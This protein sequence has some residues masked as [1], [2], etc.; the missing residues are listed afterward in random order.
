MALVVGGGDSAMEAA[1][2]IAEACATGAVTLSYRGDAFSR[3]KPK[4]RERI[5]AA[6]RDGRLEVILK[7]QVESIEP[8]QVALKTDGV[9]RNLEN[10][11]VIV[12]AGGIL[13]S[14]FLRSVGIEIETKYGT[15]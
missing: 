9:V 6:Q 2:S 8:R 3:A 10:D 1:V 14:D 13:P 12:S 11:S 15:A 7:S 4:N 5:S